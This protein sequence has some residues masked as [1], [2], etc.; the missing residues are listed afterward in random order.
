MPG[1][2]PTLPLQ[3]DPKDGF[4]LTQTYQELARQNL[5]TL[6]LTNPGERIMLPFFGVG[7]KKRLFDPKTNYANT[8]IESDIRSQ[9]AAY[10]PYIKIKQIIFDNSGDG[11]ARDDMF[12][13]LSIKITYA[14]DSMSLIDEIQVLITI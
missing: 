6:V 2:S 1:F 7:I 5:R 12:D 3:T 8:N 10:L 9:V 11:P 4:S 13:S 14:I